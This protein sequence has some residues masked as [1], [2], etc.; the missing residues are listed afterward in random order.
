MIRKTSFGLASILTTF[1]LAASPANAQIIV[2]SQG[3]TFAAQRDPADDGNVVG[4]GAIDVL[5]QGENFRVQHRDP[6]FAERAP[7]I[8]VQVGGSGGEIVY[9]PLETS[10]GLVA[11]MD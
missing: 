4:G 7:G 9:L 5:S 11:M 8:P 1:W 6:A 2:L 10:R 3:E